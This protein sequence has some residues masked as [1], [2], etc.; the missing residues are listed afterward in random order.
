MARST[1]SPRRA[2][3]PADAEAR[4]HRSVGFRLSAALD[5]SEL[6]SLVV[7]LCVPWLSI[8]VQKGPP[9][10]VQSGPPFNVV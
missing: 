2:P 8:G 6:V 10:G 1:S 7:A 9:I 3:L 5:N 4:L